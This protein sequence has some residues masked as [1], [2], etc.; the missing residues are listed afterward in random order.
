MKIRATRLAA[1]AGIALALAVT[2]GLSASSSLAAEAHRHVHH[3]H[4][5]HVAPDPAAGAGAA[6]QP[7]WGYDASPGGNSWNGVQFYRAPGANSFD[8]CGDKCLEGP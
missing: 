3:H 8:P 4:V 7:G 5:A 2:Q 6:H 1:G